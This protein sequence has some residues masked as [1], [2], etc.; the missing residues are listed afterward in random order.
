MRSLPVGTL[1]FL[2]TDIEGSTRLLETLGASYSRVLERHHA[3]VRRALAERQGIEVGT[4]GDSFF[5][6]FAD[7]GDAVAAAVDI[8]RAVTAETWPDAAAV[9]LRIGLHTGDAQVVGDDY[10]GI[11]VNRAARIMDAANGRQIVISGETRDALQGEIDGA[12]LIDTGPHRLRDLAGRA[13][14]FEVVA[15]GVPRDSRPLRTL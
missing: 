10:V 11:D 2:F 9:R 8:Q 6:V 7:P 12:D 5:A 4:Q 1:T 13:R 14:L 15:R 3:I